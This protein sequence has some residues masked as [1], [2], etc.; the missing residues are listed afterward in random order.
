MDDVEEVVFC[1][2]RPLLSVLTAVAAV[3]FLSGAVALG[4]EGIEQEDCTCA[5]GDGL[6]CYHFGDDIGLCTK[7]ECICIAA[8][9]IVTSAPSD[10]VCQQRER[11]VAILPLVLTIAMSAVG[12][13]LVVISA[14]SA[15]CCVRVV[16]RGDEE[17]LHSS[18]SAAISSNQLESQMATF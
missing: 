18:T 17:N 2:T 16:Y 3:A 8:D 6:C 9:R 4:V 13:G 12:V 14:L 11:H 15:V 5:E 7:K 1:C 10:F